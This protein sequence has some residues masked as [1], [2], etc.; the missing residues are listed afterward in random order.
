MAVDWNSYKNIGGSSSGNSGGGANTGG[1]F[2]FW[3]GQD[4]NIW[5]TRNGVTSNAGKAV[6]IAKDG[7]GF[8][9]DR[10]SMSGGTLIADPNAPAANNNGSYNTSSGGSRRSSG[11]S[12][13]ADNALNNRMIGIYDQQIGSIKNNLNNLNSQ[14]Q[15]ALA[16][17]KGEFDQY[18][19]EQQSQF[20][21][22]KNEYDKSSLQNRQDL[23]ANRNKITNNS[24]QALRGLL[25]VLGAMGASG[26]SEA[27]Y[28]VPD[29]VTRQAND[30]MSSASKVF[31]KNQQNLDT[32]WGNYKNQ[33]ENDKKKLEDWYNGQ[34]K[35]KTQENY[36][37]GQSLLNELV[38]AYG[39][40]A[41]YGGDYGN[42]IND[43]FNQIKDYSNK[44]TELGKYTTPKYTGTTAVY[45]APDLSS[46]NT[47]NTDLTASVAD[48]ST[49]AG[50]P[51]LVALQGLNKKKTNSPYGA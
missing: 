33:F 24:S 34:V 19:N 15:N 25:S 48:S 32:D 50:S 36:E 43:A 21:A 9:S 14:L 18:R 23:Q 41:Q 39:N 30:E 4:G 37:K 2:V 35:A 27:R 44:I 49:S 7:T 29:M 26:G 42:N 28:T 10:I 17:V 31:K 51:L 45:N 8:D 13:G 22:N 5:T 6:H 12:S 40:R 46:Y 20:N 38:T 1:H 3:V 47:G 11:G 16:G